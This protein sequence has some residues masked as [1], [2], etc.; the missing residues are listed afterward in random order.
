LK[1]KADQPRHP[2]PARDRAG[3]LTLIALVGAG[4]AAWIVGEIGM[5]GL[6]TYPCFPRDEPLHTRLPGW[7]GIGWALAGLNVAA[8]LVSLWAAWACWR[9]WRRTQDEA[10]GE[11]YDALEVGEGR[12]RF[13]ALCGV[14]TNI[15][16]AAAVLF[17]STGL[18][19]APTCGS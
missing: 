18:L 7:E 15:G 9:I 6:A 5:Y 12:T 13:I 14:I 11:Q 16:F 3:P 17:H 19:M 1:A 10:G 4:P 2:S 8:L